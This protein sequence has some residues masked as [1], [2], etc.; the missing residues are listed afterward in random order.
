MTA[1][2]EKMQALISKEELERAFDAR[3]PREMK[4]KFSN[5]RV[6]VAGLGGLGSNITPLVVPFSKT[7]APITGSPVASVTVPFTVMFCA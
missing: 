7:F 6:A 1:I 2:Q 4:E 5:A 3:F